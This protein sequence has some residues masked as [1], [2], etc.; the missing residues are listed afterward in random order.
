MAAPP[1]PPPFHRIGPVRPVCPVV[2]SVPHAGRGYSPALLRAARVPLHVLEA[3]EDRLVDRLVWRAVGAG[4]CAIVAHAPRA[5]IDLN[6]DERE[7]DPAI[8]APTPPARALLATARTRGGLGLVPARLAGAGALW[9]GKMSQDELDR[10]IA[11][12]HRPY[13]SA[14]AEAL[15]AARR[16]FGVAILLDCHSMPP[17]PAGEAGIVFGDRYGLTANAAVLAGATA[18]AR[19]FGFATAVNDPYAGGHVIERHGRPAKS[20]LALQ[21]EVDRSLYLDS[22]LRGP[23]EGFDQ[24]TRLFAAICEAVS[25]AALGEPPAIAAE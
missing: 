19:Q 1:D 8:V 20:V 22:D 21:I 11:T 2:L 9:R 10:R 15:T 14:V 6:R 25:A 5:Q 24:V 18:A 4:T 7:V 23:G 12:I 13:H 3:L 16:R 17:R